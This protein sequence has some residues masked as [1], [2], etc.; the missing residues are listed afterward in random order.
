MSFLEKFSHWWQVGVSAALPSGPNSVWLVHKEF[1]F[2]KHLALTTKYDEFY[3]SK[4]KDK[5]ED[6]II[7]QYVL[8]DEEK[9]VFTEP[10][11]LNI[12]LKEKDALCYLNE[13][14]N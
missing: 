1:I 4:L 12:W 13:A 2:L 14:D 8:N 9:R 10:Q 3:E 6:N 7:T 5:E 11:D